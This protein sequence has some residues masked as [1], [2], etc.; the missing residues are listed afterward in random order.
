MGFAARKYEKK[1]QERP[2]KVH[3]VWRGIGCFMAILIPV[4]AWAGANVMMGS[5]VPIKLPD[6]FNTPIYFKLTEYDWMNQAILWLNDNLGGRG[7]TLSQVAYFVIFLL[8]GF[9]V[10]VILYGVIYRL[11]GPPKYS[12]LDSPP[13]KKGARR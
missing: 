11:M 8:V 4:M 10:L 1:R 2:W 13:I 12:P 7:L 9:L 5:N 6:Q 3:P